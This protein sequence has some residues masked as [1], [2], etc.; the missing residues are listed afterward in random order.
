[1]SSATAAQL[2]RIARLQRFVGVFA[3]GGDRE[4]TAEA[5]SEL[6]R[7]ARA[8]G[9]PGD[10]L[11]RARQAAALFADDDTSPAGIRALLQLSAVFLDL[12]DTDS[13]VAAAEIAH[14]RAASFD[15]ISGSEL[16]GSASLLA[17]IAHAMAGDEGRAR[18]ALDE[19]RDTLVDAGRPDGAALALTQ[20]AL[21]DVSAGHQEGAEVCFAFARDFYRSSGQPAPAAEVT[22]L[23]VRTF[24]G[25]GWPIAEVWL[26]EGI[27]D[28]D[29]AGTTLLGAE[30]AIAHAAELER[31]GT[32][33]EA[34]E[35]AAAGLRRCQ[36]VA[37]A[38]ATREH[39]MRGRLLLARLTDETAEA[40]LH[41]EAAFELA[42]EQ[43]DPEPLGAAM[44]VVVSG[45]VKGRFTE[46][47][48][49]L[50]DR[51]RERL[52]RAGFAELS[53]AAVV[54]LAELRR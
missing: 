6:S 2:L 21:L 20:Q 5:L 16:R 39:V 18:L 29:R 43:R 1:M 15:G 36:L 4:A 51:F 3:R 31:T 49:K 34:R 22:A 47:G 13:A 50:V 38:R 46:V 40:L 42:L 12:V 41:L 27:A 24:S 28:A 54:A 53:E 26:L 9:L 19:A 17:G 23:A 32:R 8:G 48:W 52:E 14:Q 37:D 33:K 35:H 45:L 10:A 11:K 44:E 7:V 30:L 25:A